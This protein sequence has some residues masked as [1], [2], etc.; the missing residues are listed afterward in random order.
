MGAK[1][2]KFYTIELFLF[3]PRS[4]LFLPGTYQKYRYRIKIF[5]KTQSRSRYFCGRYL[6]H[7]F[8]S[9]FLL[10]KSTKQAIAEKLYNWCVLLSKLG[11]CFRKKLK[12]EL[13]SHNMLKLESIGIV[14]VSYR[15]LLK[16]LYRKLYLIQ[17]LRNVSVSD[18]F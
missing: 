15:I 11:L 5:L 12:W 1:E 7:N 17:I 4:G 18:T 10:H 16:K 6:L 13:V 8:T 2:C 9:N 3:S 14:S